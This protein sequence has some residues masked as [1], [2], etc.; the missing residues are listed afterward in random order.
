MEDILWE[1]DDDAGNWVMNKK[2]VITV[3]HGL[4][5]AIWYFISLCS[6]N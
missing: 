6:F 5:C 3:E 4:I 1:E 2:V